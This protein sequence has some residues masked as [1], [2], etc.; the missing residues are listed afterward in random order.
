MSNTPAAVLPTKPGSLVEGAAGKPLGLAGQ[1]QIVA[2]T[3]ADA[4]AAEAKPAEEKAAKAAEKADGDALAKAKEIARR[5]N[6]A[7]QAWAKAQSE[8][9]DA[10]RAAESERAA[11]APLR[12][13]IAKA[14][15]LEAM[16]RSDPLAALQELGV[17][18]ED[19][20]KR[21]VLQGKPEA[22]IAQL[23]EELATERQAREQFQADIRGQ[24]HAQQVRALEADFLRR[25]GETETY[26]ALANT[27][28]SIL[29]KAAVKLGE[30]L[31]AAT[32]QGYTNQELLAFL[33]QQYAAHQKAS[34]GD[35]A[36]TGTKAASGA[37]DK[38]SSA[39]S[40]TVSNDLATQSWS[41]PANWQELG[42]LEQRRLIAE[43]V[44]GR[45]ISRRT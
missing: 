20:Y 17:K 21:A 2:P 11:N 36:E 29:L 14:E 39:T 9:A 38:K 37:K 44:K 30:E 24:Q 33:N 18:A 42:D 22:L 23:R 35:K 3:A 19:A 45:L 5:G 12:E 40:R 10:V 41:K 8:K 28:P 26:P 32:K 31:F 4:K 15:R 27:P 25:C 1:V 34:A 7:R 16:L 43:Q 13:R 6:A